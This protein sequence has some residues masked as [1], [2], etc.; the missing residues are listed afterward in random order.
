MNFIFN[1][2]KVFINIVNDN[3]YIVNYSNTEID[4]LVEEQLWKK[5]DGYNIN[6]PFKSNLRLLGFYSQKDPN[7]PK[8][9]K[10]VSTELLCNFIKHL[11]NQQ[12]IKT[13]S[14]LVLEAD[15]S[16]ND[17]LI[18]KVYKPLG[19]IVRGKE[20]DNPEGSTLLSVS[21]MTILNHCRKIVDLFGHLFKTFTCKNLDEKQF[22]P[23]LH[24]QEVLDYFIESR[25]K[26]LLLYHKLGSGKSCSSIMIA[27]KMLEKKMINRVIVLSQG[28]LR[29][30]WSLEYCEVCGKT[31]AMFDENFVFI[32]YNSTYYKKIKNLSIDNTLIIIDEIQNFINGVINKSENNF[33][34]YQKLLLSNCRILTLSGT[35]VKNKLGLLYLIKLLNPK[36]PLDVLNLDMNKAELVE[37]KDSYLRGIVSYFPGKSGMYPR[38]NDQII[39]KAHMSNVQFGYYKNMMTQELIDMH[40]KIKPNMLP[41]E[42]KQIISDKVAAIRRIKS[43]LIS[44]VYYDKLSKD[45]NY[46]LLND[47]LE[48]QGG[49]IT[50]SKL[51]NNWIKTHSQKLYKLLVNIILHKHTKHM[52]YTY[53]VSHGGSNLINTLLNK[54][55]INSVIFHGKLTDVDRKKILQTYN[56]IENINGDLIKVIIVTEAGAEGISLLDTNNIHIFES[57]DNVV[58]TKQALGRVV[59]Y[60]SH[61]RLPVSRQYVNTYRYW[62]IAPKNENQNDKLI[63]EILYDRGV[64][65]LRELEQLEQQLIDNS[66]HKYR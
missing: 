50:D 63:D 38:V 23:Q 11:K 29:A 31:P 40:A 42:I 19:L 57:S 64:E 45:Y 35:P 60:K 52:V 32:A 26:G 4:I 24:Q 65:I 44:N 27:D 1:N 22:R 51:Q 5:S 39:I 58:K 9:K 53:F 41:W 3:R 7:K 12:I 34:F 30:N 43:R 28:S 16:V 25:Y 66:I 55:G 21:I 13:N 20:S 18:E 14:V 15:P 36:I 62:S 47:T 17:M 37:V 2:E 56:S 61:I 10:G 6:R 46:Q 49:W 59:R 33:N 8:T 48:T 54:C